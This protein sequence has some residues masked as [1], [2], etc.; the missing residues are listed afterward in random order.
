[1]AR[2][3]ATPEDSQV[4]ERR[5]SAILRHD[6]SMENQEHG[7]R[8]VRRYFALESGSPNPIE[9]LAKVTTARA[10]GQRHDLWD[11]HTADGKWW[12]SYPRM[13][14]YDQ[15]RLPSPEL[16]LAFH[17]GSLVL[18]SSRPKPEGTEEERHRF[19]ESWRRWRQATQALSEADEA[20]EI[21]AVGMRCRE[22]LLSLIR[23]APREK[24]LSPGEAAPQSS[25]FIA[26]TG[27]LAAGVAAGSSSERLRSYLRSA[28]KE[29]W[30]YVNW[31]THAKNAIRF[32]GQIAV[33][34]TA[35]VLKSF[36]MAIVRYE[37]GSPDRC[38]AC[39]SYRLTVHFHPE[40]DHYDDPNVI[41]CEAC[42]W[43]HRPADQ[44]PKLVR[45]VP[46]SEDDED[47]QDRTDA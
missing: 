38:P 28:A 42:G 16:A 43:E 22:C 31:L 39:N 25:N 47:M 23:E 19:A 18:E 20:E 2:R 5:R 33:D 35:H 21:Q 14:I 36:A 6:L 40:G 32:D 37:E 17:L 12:V 24:L 10:W 3:L 15:D 1:V 7:E 34:A 27:V 41:L 46:R 45:L 13:S 11:I 44:E 29:T 30:E 8:A 4:C 26:W 9:Y